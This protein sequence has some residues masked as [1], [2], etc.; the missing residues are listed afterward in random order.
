MAILP[1]EKLVPAAELEAYV[2]DPTP[3]AWGDLLAPFCP[4][5]PREGQ[6]IMASYFGDVFVEDRDGAVWW[7]NGLETRVDRIAINRDNALKRIAQDHLVTLKT[8]LMEQLIVGDRLLP[9]G[10]V[11]GLTTPRSEGGRYHPDNVGTA[12]IADAFAYLGDQFKRRSASPPDAPE[13]VAAAAPA[14][15]QKKQKSGSGLWGKKK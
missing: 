4:P 9:V 14:A 3:F 7:V 13:P 11:Y 8:R 10:M 12:R 5:L 15:K 6:V 1:A 2:M